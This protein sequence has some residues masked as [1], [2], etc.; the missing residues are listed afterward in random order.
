[1]MP[2][3]YSANGRPFAFVP[4]QWYSN[5]TVSP[6]GRPLDVDVEVGDRRE[7]RRPVLAHLLAPPERARRVRRLLAPVVLVEACDHRVDV[8]RVLRLREALDDCA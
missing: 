8:V 6:A 2:T 1:M 4:V 7:Q 5:Q 3:P